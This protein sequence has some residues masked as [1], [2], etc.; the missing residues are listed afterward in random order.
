MS[1]SDLLLQQLVVRKVMRDTTFEPDR[2]ELD[3]ADK[4]VTHS[5]VFRMRSAFASFLIGAGE[6]L[7]P[8]YPNAPCDEV[9]SPQSCA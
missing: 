6:R 7:R 1:S 5:P 9:T 8:H 4:T 2:P 3:R